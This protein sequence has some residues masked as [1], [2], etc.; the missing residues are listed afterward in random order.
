MTFISGIY[1]GNFGIEDTER[2]MRAFPGAPGDSA[3]KGLCQL[4]VSAVEGYFFSGETL[5]GHG[6]DTGWEGTFY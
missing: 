3:D 2:A 6:V 5:R 1:L 4:R